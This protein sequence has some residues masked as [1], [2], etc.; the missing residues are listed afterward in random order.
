MND[1]A[2]ILSTRIESER[3][4]IFARAQLFVLA[5]Y[6]IAILETVLA[7][8]L[9]LTSITMI[10]TAIISLL[11]ISTSAVMILAVR[12]RKELPVWQEWLLFFSYL[13]I[14]LAAYGVWVYH[15]QELRI[16]GL[17]NAIIAVT[18]VLFYTSMAQS[19]LMSIPTLVCHLSVVYCGIEFHGQPGSLDRELFLALCLLPAFLLVSLSSHYVNSKR[20]QLQNANRDLALANGELSSM[21]CMLRFERSR[22]QI[23]LELAH[24]VQ[25]AFFPSAPPQAGNWDVAFISKPHSGVSGDF[26]DFYC[27]QD[28][29]EGISLFDVSGHGVAPALITIL[30]KPV[31]FKNFMSMR[32]RPLGDVLDASNHD[33]IRDLEDVNIFIT[34]MMLRLK[35]GRVE[36]VNAGHPEL[37][38]K[39]ARSGMVEIIDDADGQSKG[40]PIGISLSGRDYKTIGFDVESGDMLLLYSDCLLDCRNPSGSTYGARRL[41]AAFASA[42]GDDAAEVLEHIV[43]DFSDYM[44]GNALSDDMTIIVARKK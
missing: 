33:L 39:S 35:D 13:V 21:N 27:T 38:V 14:Y 6:S 40:R 22:A 19:L 28:I 4:S 2:P 23:E 15:L 24:D 36:Y 41:M 20:H 32:N 26:Y 18:V 31:L 8:L 9:G 34:G 30:A 3:Y 11:V 43:R 5:G 17:L 10:E 42:H 1:V 29:L 12:F 44:A 16:L 7:S 37:M 25:A